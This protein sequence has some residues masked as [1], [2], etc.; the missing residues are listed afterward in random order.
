MKYQAK[1]K[2][3]ETRTSS[4]IRAI[5]YVGGLL[6]VTFTGGNSA[7]YRD[8]PRSVVDYFIKAASQGSFFNTYIKN[9]YQHV[10]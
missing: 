4:A 7:T 5:D 2:T 9:V 10:V 8:V 1:K 3:H 6:K